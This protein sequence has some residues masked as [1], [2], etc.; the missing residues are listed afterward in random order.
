MI[1]VKINPQI[2]RVSI[3]CTGGSLGPVPTAGHVAVVLFKDYPEEVKN[4]IFQFYPEGDG[5]TFEGGVLLKG[6]G[7][8]SWAREIV[9]LMDKALRCM[10]CGR[11]Y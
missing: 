5:G 4:W 7:W 1:R 3:D 10:A 6:Y 8:P 9:E 2:K 11:P